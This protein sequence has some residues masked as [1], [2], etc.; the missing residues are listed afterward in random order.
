MANWIGV[1]IGVISLCIAYRQYTE[2]IKVEKAVRDGLARLAGTIQVIYSNA[3]WSEAHMRTIAKMLTDEMPKVPSVS[4]EAVDGARD[5]TT[6]ER[7]LY[8]ALNQIEGIQMLLFNEAEE[9]LPNGDSDDIKW[10]RSRLDERKHRSK[11]KPV[12][13]IA[14]N[15]R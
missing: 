4:K 2:R 9:I 14:P 12:T 13:Q 5:A 8:L 3:K 10:A 1:I 15:V 7:Q 11:E 6:C